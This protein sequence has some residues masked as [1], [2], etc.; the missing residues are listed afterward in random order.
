MA[1]KDIHRYLMGEMDAQSEKEFERKLNEDDELKKEYELQKEIKSAVQEDDI[2]ELREQLED[3]GHSEKS[4]RKIHLN[5]SDILS[6]AASITL[7][8]GVGLLMLFHNQRT[9]P[10]DLYAS[11]FEPYPNIYSQRSVGGNSSPGETKKKAFLAY[12]QEN[13]RESKSYFNELLEKNPD[14]VEYTFYLG[15]LN[16]KLDN[17]DKAIEQFQTILQKNDPLFKGQTTWYI[18]LGYLRKSNIDKSAY[19]LNKIIRE[20]MANK[21][22]ASE[23]IKKLE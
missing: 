11:Y 9:Y 14:N 16:L 23:L 5:R 10:D 12:E 18:A 22:K 1:N 6:I 19:F 3:L 8:I 17:P 21:G 15:V 2:M 7:F 13:W 20:D 4:K